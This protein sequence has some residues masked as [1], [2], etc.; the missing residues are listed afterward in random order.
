M[1]VA[2]NPADIVT[3][4]EME[5][6]KDLNERQARQ[7]AAII[8]ERNGWQGVRLVCGILPVSRNT[9]YRGLH[10]LDS[11]E[12]LEEGRVRKEGGGR[13]S[14]LSV[15]PEYITIFREIV[16]F[17]IA[18]L[19]QD[20]KTMWL[21][22]TPSQIQ[23]IFS[24]QY[25]IEISLYTVR[26]IVKAEGFTRRKPV[27]ALPMADCE[28]RDEQFKVIEQQRKYCDEHGIP[29]FSV[30]TKKKE[31]LG[32][33]RRDER[34]AY[35]TEAVKVYDHDYSTFSNGKMVPYGIYDVKRNTGYM[36]FGVSHDTAEFA[37]DCF[38]QQWEQHLRHIYPSAKSILILCDGGGSNNARSWQFKWCLIQLAKR[39]AINIRIAHYPPYCSKWNPIEH[40]LFSQISRVWSGAVFNT[41][42]EA[43]ELASRARTK[44]GL[45]VSTSINRRIYETKTERNPLFES[46]CARHIV[47]DEILPKWNYLVRCN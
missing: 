21:R 30:D 25:H 39:L 38:A 31:L 45:A 19:P 7:F 47:K 14:T 10:E 3:D 44:T 11:G 28:L 8:A 41:I 15:H 36:T 37:C 4:K 43:S 22:L 40:R 35:T 12:H 24:E 26:Q 2:N 18:G 1:Q 23:Q 6:F 32:P 27:K 42:E 34:T 20:A 5:Y 16:V 29:V 17:D 13:K 46:E 33:Y 9:V